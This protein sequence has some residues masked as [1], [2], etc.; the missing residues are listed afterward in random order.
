MGQRVADLAC[1]GM[2]SDKNS[3][4]EAG[5]L[6]SGG[7]MKLTTTNSH[8]EGRD[9]QSFGSL[10][11]TT[12]NT[13]L[14]AEDCAAKGELRL[15]TSNGKLETWRSDGASVTLKTSNSSIRGTLAGRQQDWAIESHTS[16]GKNSLPKSQPGAKPLSVHTSNGSI[17]LHFEQA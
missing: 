2:V 17:D 5:G 16:N 15:I 9:L 8:I 12:S 14:L 7:D 11:L 3:R 6:R 4:I 13:G 10:Y 1:S